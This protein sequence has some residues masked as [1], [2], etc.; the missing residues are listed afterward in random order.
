MFGIFFVRAND[1]AKK[2]LPSH[3]LGRGPVP[4]QPFVGMAVYRMVLSAFKETKK[5]IHPYY[6]QNIIIRANLN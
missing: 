2:A 6:F 3:L 1:F 4:P 5:L